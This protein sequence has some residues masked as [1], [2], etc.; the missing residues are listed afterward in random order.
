LPTGP[1]AI[2]ERKRSA[3]ELIAPPDTTTARGRTRTVLPV[4]ICV[5]GRRN[6]PITEVARLPDRSIFSTRQFA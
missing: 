5:P 2:P 4:A 6:E 3:G 1:S